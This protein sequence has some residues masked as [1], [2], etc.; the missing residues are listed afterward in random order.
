VKLCAEHHDDAVSEKFDVDKLEWKT[1][2]DDD[3]DDDDDDAGKF[4]CS[5]ALGDRAPPM[6]NAGDIS[7]FEPIEWR[8]PHDHHHDDDD[9]QRLDA[10]LTQ[11]DDEVWNIGPAAA[12]GDTDWHTGRET[13]KDRLAV[14]HRSSSTIDCEDRGRET[15]AEAV[16]VHL[17]SGGGERPDAE[18]SWMA[19]YRLPEPEADSRGSS[20]GKRVMSDRRSRRRE[21]NVYGGDKRRRRSPHPSSVYR[22]SLLPPQP[23]PATLWQPWQDEGASLPP[24]TAVERTGSS[25]QMALENLRC[26]SVLSTAADPRQGTSASTVATSANEIATS[27]NR[28]T[29]SALP[30]G[31]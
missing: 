12:Q 24:E 11:R 26:L 30:V 4:R 18:S 7:T 17:S 9:D 27:R 25:L 5:S 29:S 28:A 1:F 19:G 3:D 14:R 10:A 16:S 8:P 22:L 20:L 23:K 21:K 6:E 2:N 15:A 13:R 31:K